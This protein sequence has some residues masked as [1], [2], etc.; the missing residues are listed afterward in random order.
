VRVD[1]RLSARHPGAAAGRADHRETVE[2]LRELVA[3]GARLH[4]ASDPELATLTVLVERSLE[5]VSEPA[6]GSGPGDGR[7]F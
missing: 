4:G 6:F 3:T 2:Y 7:K 5:P 1:R